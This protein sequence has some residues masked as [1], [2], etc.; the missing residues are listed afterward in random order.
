MPRFLRFARW[1]AFTL[2]ELLVVIAIIAV[3]MGLLVPAV[4]KVREVG[5]RVVSTNNLK[6]MTLATA[7]MANQN[8]GKLPRPYHYYYP[9]QFNNYPITGGNGPVFFHILPYMEQDT[10][11]KS[12]QWRE[13]WPSNY[14]PDQSNRQ[15]NKGDVYIDVYWAVNARNK[16]VKAFYA[17][18]DPTNDPASGRTSY[19]VNY[20]AFDDRMRHDR[21]N[22]SLNNADWGPMRYPS[23][24]TDGTS[25]TIMFAEQYSQWTWNIPPVGLQNI[26]RNWWDDSVFTGFDETYNPKTGTWGFAPRSPPAFQV[27][28]RKDQVDPGVPQALSY[29]GL[30]VGMADGSVRTVSPGVSMRT[31]MALC[32][33]SGKDIPGN[34]F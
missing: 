15:W 3:L 21:N 32:T 16:P 17:P 14:G 27:R 31:W 4:Q 1:R 9:N 20:D 23:N 25:S 33:P 34:D 12:T 8:G 22:P 18:G 13:V 6:Q 2:I 11:Y 26:D 5:N 24:F 19:T 7:N 28:P 30:Q 10:V 29:G